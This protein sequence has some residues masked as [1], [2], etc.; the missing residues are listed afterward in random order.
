M[1]G[2]GGGAVS[3]PTC[4]NFGLRK[5]LGTEP[6]RD[7]EISVFVCVYVYFKNGMSGSCG[8]FAG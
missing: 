7:M 1:R 5:D 2:G 8:R 4:I 6:I 3:T